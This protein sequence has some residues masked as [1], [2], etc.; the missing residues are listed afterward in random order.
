VATK[1]ATRSEASIQTAVVDY[2]RKLGFIAIKLSTNGRFGTSGWPDYMFLD[3]GRAFFMEFKR[4]GGVLTPKQA[5]RL[6]A[7]R[8]AGF[9]GWVV[10][11][12]DRGKQILDI[13]KLE[14]P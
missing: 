10:E 11:S 9:D 5:L 6:T 1:P 3:R 2:A 7:L 14:Q 8:E 13:K 12:V 4:R